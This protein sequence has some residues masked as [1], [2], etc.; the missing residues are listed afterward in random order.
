[1]AIIKSNPTL[2]EERVYTDVPVRGVQGDNFYA[3]ENFMYERITDTA[4][5]S[6]AR[7]VRGHVHDGAEESR[8]GRGILRTVNGGFYLVEEGGA[9]LTGTTSATPPG[10]SIATGLTTHYE[11][12]AGDYT[13]GIAHVSPGVESIKVEYLVRSGGAAVTSVNIHNITDDTWSGA[14]VIVALTNWYTSGAIAVTR[15][16]ANRSQVRRIEL[17]IWWFVDVGS[18]TIAFYHAFP[19]EYT[20]QP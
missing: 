10:D 3:K 6:G 2:N 16:A 12:A 9:Y 5:P 11:D 19:F 13:I 7:S 20:D 1:V 8:D 4:A 15:T 17:D 14:Q 18:D